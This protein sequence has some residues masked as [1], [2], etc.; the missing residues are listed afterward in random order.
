MGQSHDVLCPIVT[1][2]AAGGERVDHDALATLTR[3]LV[4]AGLDG[5]VP[6]G[7]TGE[8]AALSGAERDAVVETVVEAAGDARVIAGAG[9]TAPADVRERLRAAGAAGADAAMVVAPYY[10]GQASAAGY[11]RFYD[12]VLAD[13]GLPIYLYNMP[14]AAGVELP[15]DAVAA[16]ADRE[17]VAGIKDSSGDL[18]YLDRVLRRT[19]ESFETFVGSGSAFT[20]ALAMGADGGIVAVAHFDPST[21]NALADA[22]AESDLDRARDLQLGRIDP[23]VDVLVEHDFAA[24][25]KA[26]LAER[27]HLPS[28]AVRPPACPVPTDRRGD[29]STSVP[30]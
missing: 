11:E 18:G 13:A 1:P 20:G 9:G 29:L 26:V 28:A 22:V 30:L 3:R 19:P 17:G 27:G 8:F 16:L 21:M 10:G 25:V 15:V 4:D 6:C 5:V 7:T 2:L 24:A 14:P 12:A 23:T